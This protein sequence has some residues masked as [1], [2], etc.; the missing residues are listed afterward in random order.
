MALLGSSLSID[1]GLESKHHVVGVLCLGGWGGFHAYLKHA[2][3][4]YPVLDFAKNAK[5]KGL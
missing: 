4:V 3:Y 5:E 2:F 1:I